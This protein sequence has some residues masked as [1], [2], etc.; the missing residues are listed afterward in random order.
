MPRLPALA[1]SD[2]RAMTDAVLRVLPDT[3]A[4]YVFGSRARGDAGPQS[5]LDLAVLATAP[6][7]PLRRFDAQRELSVALD[8]D[9]DLIDLRRASSVL[10]SEVI[11]GGRVLFRRDADRLLAFEA[12][13]LGEYADLL[14]ATRDLREHVRARGRVHV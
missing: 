11:H 5:D 10:R 1:E 8:V 13:V 3:E 12:G 6:L 2:T 7:D 4:L 9:V 14:D